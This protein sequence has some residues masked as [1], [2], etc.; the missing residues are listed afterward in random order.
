MNNSKQKQ[1]LFT[2]VATDDEEHLRGGFGAYGFRMAP[3][4]IQRVPVANIS[5]PQPSL[6]HANSGSFSGG[7]YFDLQ[8]YIFGMGAAYLFG[9]PGVTPAEVQYVWQ[10]ALRLR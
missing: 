7:Y 10:M 3:S 1:N 2:Q 6:G 4:R 5:V 8:A 9:N